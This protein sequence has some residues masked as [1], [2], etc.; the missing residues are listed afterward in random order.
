MDQQ[1]QVDAA[2][3]DFQKAFDKVDHELLLNKLTY[4]GIRGDL[5]RWFTSYVTNKSQRVVIKGHQSQPIIVISGVLQ[6]SILGPLLFFIFINDIG[7]CFA[8]SKF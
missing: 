7:R 3:T 4:N 2:Y 5:L 6:G 1:T 8:N